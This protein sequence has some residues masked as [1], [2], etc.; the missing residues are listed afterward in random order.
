MKM[1]SVLVM[2]SFLYMSCAEKRILP[3]SDNVKISRD[4]PSAECKNLGRVQGRTISVTPNLE[5]AIED[6]KK[7]ASYKGANYVVMETAS[8]YDTA[9]SGTAFYCP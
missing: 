7:E 1:L 8:G 6:M 5:F 2:S 9:V 3:G 4:Q